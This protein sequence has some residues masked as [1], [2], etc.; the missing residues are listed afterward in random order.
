L[1]TVLRPG[2][3]RFA[4]PVRFENIGG[5]QGDTDIAGLAPVIV[6]VQRWRALTVIMLSLELRPPAVLT[7]EP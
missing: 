5:T 1:R 6:D 7:R 2:E 3:D 4:V